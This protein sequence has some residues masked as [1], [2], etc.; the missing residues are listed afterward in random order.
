MSTLAAE[1][2][3]QATP[4]EMREALSLKESVTL[5]EG[6]LQPDGTVILDLLRPC[7]GR[8]RGRHVYEADM[9]RE[10][11]QNLVGWKMFVDHESDEARKR[12][13]GLPRSIRD[14][15]GRIVESWWNPDVPADPDKGFG[16]GAVQGRSRP[17]RFVRELI[18]DDPEIVECSINSHATGVRPVLKEGGRAWLVEGIQKKG[19]VDWVTDGGAGGR[20]AS[21]MESVYN[22]DDAEEDALLESLTDEALRAHI[23]KERPALLEAMKGDPDGG[24]DEGTESDLDKLIEK[25]KGNG[26]PQAAAEKA[27]RKALAKKVQESNDEGG[28]GEVEITADALREAFEQDETRG[29]ILDL[30]RECAQDDLRSL[31]EAGLEEERSLI[32]RESQAQA[33]R[34]LTLRDMRDSAH[35]IV[36]ASKLPEKFQEVV[37]SRFTLVEGVPT[38][39]LDVID[40]VDDDGNVTK[41]ASDKLSEAV[42]AVIEEQRELVGSL[43]PAAVRGQ[44]PSAAATEGGGT[45]GKTPEELREAENK[46]KYSVPPR[47]AALLQEAGF[48]KPDEVFAPA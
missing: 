13:G 28:N 9:L 38:S 10:N 1:P 34:Q 11:A 42:T 17:T 40:D 5:S 26:M 31:V 8:G 6:A 20:V 32:R 37:K 25:F 24:A 41:S 29:M 2:E 4:G 12:A 35:E 33:E 30:V 22:E 15:G 39:D 47:T 46:A 43:R 21:L 14:L 48:D 36:E 19:T 27:A 3:V 7:V 45:E 44:G 23:A 16:P 18:E